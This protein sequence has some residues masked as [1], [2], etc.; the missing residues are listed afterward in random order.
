MENSFK[1]IVEK[2]KSVL[3]LLPTKPY[4]DQV[5]AGLSLF[6]VL[7]EGKDVQIYS[8]TPITVD[9]NRLV[10]V[11]KI[12]SELGNKNLIIRFSDY[13]ASDIERVS[14]DIEDGQFRLT[15]IPKQKILPPTKEQID[16]SY[17]GISADTVII[18]GGANDS[19]FPALSSKELVDASI[20]H[21]GTRDLSLSTGKNYI[22][23]SKPVSSVSEVVTNLINESG[24]E[25]NED[26]ATN[27]LMGIEDE[28]GGYS[29]NSV[30]AETFAIVSELMKKGGKRVNLQETAKM[31][32][33]PPG[34]I[35]GKLP[36][37]GN[38]NVAATQQE[39]NFTE[40]QKTEVDNGQKN[41]E[42][43]SDQ[44]TPKD[45]LKPKIFKGTSVS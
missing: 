22:S 45:W 8:P 20:V 11:N 32:D 23:F 5:A 37:V 18:V 43:S 7:R 1:S 28:S 39:G 36:T 16:L 17:S 31:D 33:Y 27:L 26:V 29:S 6:L 30:T 24:L 4:F 2:S 42:G 40:A 44:G 25:I 9:L 10:G 13:K 15:V 34:S 12:T 38:Q 3:I 21:I 14:Y 41:N 35:P 19:H